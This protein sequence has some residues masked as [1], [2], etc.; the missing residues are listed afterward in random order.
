MCHREFLLRKRSSQ[1]IINNASPR[2]DKTR[3]LMMA[4]KSYSLVFNGYWREKNIA[5]IPKASGVY[6]VYA[7]TYQSET[8]SLLI[9][10]LVYIGEAGDVNDRIAKHEKWP[11][12][13]KH[14]QQGEELCFNFASVEASERS[15]VEAALIFHHKPSE[16]SEYKDT[17]PFDETTISTDGQNSLLDARFTVQKTIPEDQK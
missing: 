17:F 13:R 3:V 2:Y 9:R 16:N 5:G 12:W 1:G 14:R 11:G 8:N 10:L 7:C 4:A 6:C 15:R